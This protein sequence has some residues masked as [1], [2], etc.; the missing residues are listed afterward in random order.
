M[1]ELTLPD[2]RSDTLACCQKDEKQKFLLHNL[3]EMC[4]K[5][6]FEMLKNNFFVSF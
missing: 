4:G 6:C 5:D 2:A 1:R 3:P